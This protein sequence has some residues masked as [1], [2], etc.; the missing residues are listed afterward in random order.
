[1]L[2]YISPSKR[3]FYMRSILSIFLSI[4][5]LSFT[6][7]DKACLDLDSE[8]GSFKYDGKKRKYHVH[9]PNDFEDSNQV[10]LLIGLHGLGGNGCGLALFAK[11]NRIADTANFVVVYP[12]GIDKKWNVQNEVFDN[13]QDDIG[14]IEELISQM[15]LDY[16]IDLDRVYAFGMSN[17]GYMA[18]AIACD[19][20]HKVAAVASVTGSM[21]P[22]QFAS[23]NP[24]SPVPIL[25][26]HGTS[27]NT[28]PMA[29]NLYTQPLVEVIN[30]WVDKNAC[31]TDLGERDF[32]SNQSCDDKAALQYNYK[33][34]N[35][36]ADVRF[37]VVEEGKHFWWCWSAEEI[38]TFFD[39]H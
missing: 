28:V 21:T 29:G 16:N 19:L 37:I 30:F 1:M 11:M 32:S 4:T 31:A 17:G 3:F 7:C 26:I 5:M 27:D 34:C 6:S 15:Q 8:K 39:Q 33:D 35:N 22:E 25:Q 13:G 2:Q 38:W 20:G 9:L 36:N 18:H 10:P 23:C 14:Y 24:T 12:N